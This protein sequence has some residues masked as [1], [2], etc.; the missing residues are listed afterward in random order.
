MIEPIG[1]W[2]GHTN[3]ARRRPLIWITYHI[4]ADSDL[5]PGVCIDGITRQVILGEARDLSLIPTITREN[6]GLY[7]R[8]GQFLIAD[9]KGSYYVR[10]SVAIDL[11]TMTPYYSTDVGV[12][13]KKVVCPFPAMPGDSHAIKLLLDIDNI[14]L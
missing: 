13:L 5:D 4:Y 11:E 12:W 2:S 3:N 8:K 10:N 9:C 7:R 6:G 14:V 1:P